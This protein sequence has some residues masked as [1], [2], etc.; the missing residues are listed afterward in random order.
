MAFCAVSGLSS[1]RAPNR[2]PHR[3][4]IFGASGSGTSTLGERLAH[5]VGGRFL[6][7]DTYYWMKTE[8]PFTDKRPIPERVALLESHMQGGGNCV[9]S[10]SLCSWGSPLLQYFTAAV[11]LHLDPKVRMAR[12]LERETRRNGERIEPGGDLHAAHVE[13]IDWARSY[14]HAKVPIRSLDMHERWMPK[15]SCPVI[16]L[17]SSRPLDELCS[18]LIERLA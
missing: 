10:G 7:T 8:P 18:T 14:D 15:L 13:F 2:V 12:L 9:L 4:H 17:D 16:R 11:F 3:I 6:D 1:R 5:E